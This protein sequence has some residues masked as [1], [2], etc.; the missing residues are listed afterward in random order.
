MKKA[1]SILIMAVFIVY[2]WSVFAANKQE[3][4]IMVYEELS[5][6]V[7]KQTEDFLVELRKFKDLN[8]TAVDQI[9]FP[10]SLKISM[11][12]R[13]HSIITSYEL[14]MK[15]AQYT[16][17]NIADSDQI[18]LCKNEIQKFR[19]DVFI[20]LITVVD[21]F[22]NMVVPGSGQTEAVSALA[23]DISISCGM[24]SAE[25]LTNTLV[26]CLMI[27]DTAGN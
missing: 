24:S 3:T 22:S 12:K 20:P 6:K 5:T 13:L 11:N 26:N 2:S 23:T 4:G 18:K 14:A 15:K 16:N 8:K 10:E 17:V 25:F 1:N 19:H 21:E 9:V 7:M 27:L